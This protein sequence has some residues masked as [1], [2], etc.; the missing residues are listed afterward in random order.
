PMEELKRMAVR[1]FSA[2]PNHNHAA[3]LPQEK[4]FSDKQEGHIIAI[5]P[6]K[7]LRS[8]SIY[9]ELPKAFIHNFDDR[10][11]DLL[12]YVIGGRYEKSLRSVLKKEELINNIGSSMFRLS[13]DS[14]MFYISM[15][16]TP[17]GAEQFEV[18]IERCFQT[19][20]A[21]KRTGI[22]SY[23]FHELK[24]MARIDYEYTSRI[25]PFH[26][27]ST[28][29]HQ[30]ID[31][32]LGTYPLK[33]VMPTTYNPEETQRFLELLTPESATYVLLA[34]PE[35]SG[36]IP[37]RKEKWSNVE[38][39]VRKIPES[40][41]T[42]WSELPAHPQIALPEQNTFI[43]NDLKLVNHVKEEEDVVIPH[44][45]KLISNDQGELFVWEDTQYLVPEVS[46]VF[47]ISSPYIDGSP[48]QAV[49]LDLFR[50]ALDEK[51]ASTLSYA[52]A[53]SLGF[54]TTI[55]DL[56]LVVTVGGYSEKAPLLLKEGLQQAKKCHMTKEEFDLY[57]TDLKS[58]YANQGKAMPIQQAHEI[59]QNLL[60]SNAPK[61]S[62]KLIALETIRYEDYLSFANHLFQEAY[63]EALMI[64]NLTEKDALSTWEMILETLAYAPY[65]RKNHE[66]KQ[67]LT[68]SSFQGPYKIP[69][70][71]D[72]LGNAAI[73][74]I[75]E[76]GVTFPKK[77]SH[78]VLG[79]GLQE[80]FFDTLRTKQQTGYV[81]KVATQEEEQQLYNLFMV[82]SS[83]H[84]PDE[85]ISRFELFLETY[86]KDFETAIPEG[87]FEVLR[88]N[89]ITLLETPPTNLGQMASQLNYLAFTHKGDFDRREKL[90]T[91]L[92]NLTYE[93]FKA[94]TL[95][96]L[97]RK[98]PRRIAI[99]LEGKQPDGKNFRYEGITAET[100][101]TE[102]T[103]ISLP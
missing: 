23:I 102:G 5:K 68:L 98:N 99:M 83:T 51:M 67:M 76:G 39:V 65:P 91:A 47:N 22:P 25:P 3:N 94:D 35:L 79:T 57:T 93:D 101:K 73:L 31:E 24:T 18:V 44:P 53:A 74:M 82:Q 48:R 6:I 71:T 11:A 95:S 58:L 78:V 41:L 90:A 29:A 69:M 60:F 97:S 70:Q 1:H 62:E 49:M 42:A 16:L 85:L 9:W 89:V 66:R 55:Q 75:Q 20:N 63:I 19:L 13:K 28:H 61:H 17:I 15:D 36:A 103:Y 64:G 38:Y 72:S 40:T 86:I 59:M 8:L 46:W 37:E 88:S 10:S 45:K 92:R 27:V 14:G 77:A 30:M 54:D 12:G 87:R 7:D 52:E 43:P 50:Y 26:F 21:L 33:T 4:L 84:Q 80:D 56:K 2:I 34:P 96:F 32:P 81:A 100:L